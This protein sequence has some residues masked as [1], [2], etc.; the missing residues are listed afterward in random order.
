MS[1]SLIIHSHSCP[2]LRASKKLIEATSRTFFPPFVALFIVRLIVVFPFSEF[3]VTVWD[4]ATPRATINIE[5]FY[6]CVEWNLESSIVRR[7][8][9]LRA[10]R[11]FSLRSFAF[12]P[13]R[14]VFILVKYVNE[15]ERSSCA[16]QS[17]IR[18]NYRHL[19]SKVRASSTTTVNPLAVTV[20]VALWTI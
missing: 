7:V 1:S 18:M 13:F 6:E 20:T 17:S 19:P 3:R 15:Y 11:I 9:S 16:R 8:F 2:F 4:G 14:L 10:R 5:T 12:A